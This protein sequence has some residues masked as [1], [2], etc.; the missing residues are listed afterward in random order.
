LEQAYSLVV[1]E[2][3]LLIPDDWS[4]W[5]SLRLSAL[6]ESPDAFGS[7]LADWLGDGDREDRWRARLSILG[8]RNVVAKLGGEPA[9]MASGVPFPAVSDGPPGSAGEIELISMWVAPS[10]RGHGVA[11][12]LIQDLVAWAANLGSPRLS[13]RETNARAIA[14]YRRHRFQATGE[15]VVDEDHTGATVA[16]LVFRK[17]L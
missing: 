12:V 15:R 2:L 16:E 7:R 9:G 1:I 11:D 17:A 8:S 6:A 4:V 13:V 3:R 10:A 14:F 5:R